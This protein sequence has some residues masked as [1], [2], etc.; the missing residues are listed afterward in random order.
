MFGGAY[1]W[2]KGLSF[3]EGMQ[4]TDKFLIEFLKLLY[5]DYK[6]WNNISDIWIENAVRLSCSGD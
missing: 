6:T 1:G 2:F 5:Y 4:L 3:S